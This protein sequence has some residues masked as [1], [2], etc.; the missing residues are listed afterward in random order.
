MM[1]TRD[2]LLCALSLLAGCTFST[3]SNDR[4]VVSSLDFDFTMKE[5]STTHGGTQMDIA[6]VLPLTDD[7]IASD[8]AMAAASV[9]Y[10]I[11]AR[12][13]VL[14]PP[15][16]ADGTQPEVTAVFQRLLSDD[17]HH[18]QVLFYADNNNDFLAEP[19]AAPSREHSWIRDIPSNGELVFV[20]QA[21]F[22]NFYESEIEPIGGNIVLD[23][24]D[25][26]AAPARAACLNA[27]LAKVMKSSFELRLFYNP[28]TPVTDQTV[29]FKMFS[30]NTL[31]AAPVLFTGLADEKSSFGLEQVLDGKLVASALTAMATAAGLTIPLDQWLP[32]KPEIIAACLAL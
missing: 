1:R 2:R 14:V 26:S 17:E 6:V 22:Q 20:H 7:P 27:E 23:I 31:P 3:D 25:L 16:A 4:K 11:R 28:N 30:T 15:P 32:L 5:V 9:K 18:L 29:L 21:K 13:R 8:N 19:L 10:Q 24:P 12:G